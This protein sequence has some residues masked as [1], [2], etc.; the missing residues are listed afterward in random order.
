VWIK[1]L[2][3]DLAVD[4]TPVVRHLTGNTRNSRVRRRGLFTRLVQDCERRLDALHLPP[5][6]SMTAL[7]DHISG[8]RGRPVCLVSVDLGGARPSGLW[9]AAPEADLIAYDAT[10]SRLHQRHIIAHELA[11]IICDHRA[12]EPIDD[13]TAR[14]L[15]PDLDP[16]LVR[17]SLRRTSYSDVQEME[18]EI[19]ASL[20]LASVARSATHDSSDPIGALYRVLGL[21]PSAH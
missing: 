19:T 12:V 8:S 3:P 4:R 14:V 15:F 20:I 10:T 17:E 16:Q 11:H 18:A 13:D 2:T 6:A 5:S 7:C 21:R 9:L 1:L